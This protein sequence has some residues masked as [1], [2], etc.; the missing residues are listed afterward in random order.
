M[1]VAT[2]KR[3]DQPPEH[4][5]ARPEE[6]GSSA[7]GLAGH[8]TLARRAASRTGTAAAGHQ[9][10]SREVPGVRGA[11]RPGEPPEEDQRGAARRV[12]CAT[13]TVLVAAR[14]PGGRSRVPDQGDRDAQRQQRQR[15]RDHVG[16][17]V[18][19]EER[20]ERELV[21]RLRDHARGIPEP[22]VVG[23]VQ[24]AGLPEHGDQRLRPPGPAPPAPGSCFE[25]HRAC[26]PP[27]G[28][29]AVHLRQVADHG[30]EE[31]ASKPGEERHRGDLPDLPSPGSSR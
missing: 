1:I 12:R 19:V 30:H 8:T 15:Q 3:I 20:E 21:D 10:V 29:T 25:T 13:A 23:E 24:G 7:S 17:Q 16:V 28:R 27:T 22:P 9:Q 5:D 6:K 2:A 18:G 4:G 11:Q 14:V 26:E 31:H